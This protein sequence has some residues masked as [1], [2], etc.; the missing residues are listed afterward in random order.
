[1]G[2]KRKRSRPVI[3]CYYC[4]RLFENERVLIQH[5]RAKHFKCPQCRK[6]ISSAHGMMV[7]VFQVHKETIDKVPGAKTGRASFELEIFGMD[8]VPAEI[9]LEKRIKLYGESSNNVKVIPQGIM[10]A[11]PEILIPGTPT[12]SNQVTTHPSVVPMGQ[13]PGMPGY[14]YWPMMP[15]HMGASY[16]MIPQVGFHPGQRAVPILPQWGTIPE[17]K[18]NPPSEDKSPYEEGIQT[19]KI[20]SCSSN[21]SPS[22][23]SQ[24][25][26]I[27]PPSPKT[28]KSEKSQNE[29]KC[30][31]T[32]LSAASSKPFV[33]PTALEVELQPGGGTK[34]KLANHQESKVEEPSGN[35]PTIPRSGSLSMISSP[36]SPKISPSGSTPVETKYIPDN[37]TSVIENDVGELSFEEKRAMHSR[38]SVHLRNRIASLSDSIEARLKSLQ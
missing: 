32:S 34:P 22:G 1:M 4:D 36:S 25:N 28:Q 38:Y 20:T 14:P 9:L 21:A 35:A 24:K 30:A 19:Q 23:V 12:V 2:R 3:F 8:G 33:A 7:H 13:V 6:K 29:T 16:G 10:S 15:P 11:S 26:N 5:Q 27:S 17:S 31:V 18:V 37:R